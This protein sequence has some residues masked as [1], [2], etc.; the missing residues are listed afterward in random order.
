MRDEK[1]TE[2]EGVRERGERE[3]VRERERERLPCGPVA[4]QC[5]K[6]SLVEAQAKSLLNLW[7]PAAVNTWASHAG[8]IRKPSTNLRNHLW[9]FKPL[10]FPTF[11]NPWTNMINMQAIR[12]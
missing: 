9:Q 4:L 8:A 7:F 12:T 3:R 11:V 6:R 5:F 1:E 2:R 10:W